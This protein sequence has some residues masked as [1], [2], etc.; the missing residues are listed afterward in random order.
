MFNNVI[1]IGLCLAI[2]IPA[3]LIIGGMVKEYIEPK[4]EVNPNDYERFQ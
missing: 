4:K 2:G 1:V 3:L